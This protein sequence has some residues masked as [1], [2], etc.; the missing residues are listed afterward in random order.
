MRATHLSIGVGIAA[1][2]I[3]ASTGTTSA[4]H[5]YKQ[6]WADAAY[7]HHRAGGTAW[8]SLSDLGRQFMVPEELQEA[9]GWVADEAVA[10]F[11]AIKGLEQEP[12]IHSKAT[13]GSGAY[14]K[15]RAPHRSAT[16]KRPISSCSADFSSGTC[17][18]ARAS[19]R[20]QQ[21]ESRPGCGRQHP[22]LLR[23]QHGREP[24]DGTELAVEVF[25]VLVHRPG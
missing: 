17:R 15:G 1:A 5:C 10:D 23:P 18:S 22:G 16:W 25:L 3:L 6:D 7:Q 8:V 21:L 9:C 12:L 14:A 19:P 4:H 13:T 11:M 20:S 2:L 24:V